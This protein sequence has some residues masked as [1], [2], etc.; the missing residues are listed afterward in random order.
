MSKTGG[1]RGT[2]QYQT[3]GV[4]QASRQSTAVLDDLSHE[5]DAPAVS[6]E[7]PSPTRHRPQHAAPRRT[8]VTRRI[9]RGLRRLAVAL[10][11]AIKA[12]RAK[13]KAERAKATASKPAPQRPQKA[14]PATPSRTT[15]VI[16]AAARGVKNGVVLVARSISRALRSLRSTSETEAS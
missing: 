7:A 1:G 11:D 5:E 16:K 14:S 13:A 2:N 10:F 9:A 4:G 3:Q 6:D 15:K 8:G 12:E